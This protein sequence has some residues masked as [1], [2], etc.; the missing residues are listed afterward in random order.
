MSQ[1]SVPVDWAPRDYQM[2][3]WSALE[4]GA[5][6]A[7]A[8]WHR[9][10]GKD[11][12]G[13]NWTIRE[14]FTTPGIYWHVLPTYKQGRKVIWEGKTNTGRDYLSYWPDHGIS[15]I[16]NDEMTVWTRNGSL[17]Q[18]IGAEDQDDINRL[19]GTNPRGIVF[20]EYALCDPAIW[21]FVRPILRANGGWAIFLYTPRGRNHGYRLFEMAKGQDDWFAELLTVDDTDVFTDGDIE[22]E[23]AE[24]MEEAILQQEYYCSFDA[25]LAGAYYGAEMRA[26]KEEK[27][28]TSVP[29]H[30]ELPVITAW[31]LGIAD[32]MAVWCLQ[33]IGREIHAI[34]YHEESGQGLSYFH[35]WLREQPYAYTNHLAPHD[36]MVREL[37]SG[38]SRYETAMSMGIPFFVVPKLSFEDGVSAVR[39]LLHRTW[40]DQMR[41][42]TG[43]S[44]LREYSRQKQKGTAGPDGK[45]VFLQ[46]PARNWAT[47]GADAFRTFAMG[48][49]MVAASTY[50]GPLA[51]ELPIA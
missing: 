34:N 35:K 26:A 9:R 13:I 14:A 44:A 19:V 30:E 51:P 32:A 4:H 21:D 16:R 31:D 50:S 5:K 39:G 20:S 33:E 38:M 12:V 23:R 24:G 29:W 43:I 7:V 25:P 3:L 47:H 41:C 6:R 45:P 36:I 15:R 46:T 40:F 49:K 18:V 11:S 27:R 22:K 1:V 37:G 42:K 48:H 10:C 17:W 28:I 8:I 2:P